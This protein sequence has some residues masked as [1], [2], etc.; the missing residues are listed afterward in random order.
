MS[1]TLLLTASTS[2]GSRMRRNRR[3]WQRRGESSA[4]D[5]GSSLSIISTAVRQW[6]ANY[7][8]RHLRCRA[9]I[10]SVR[11][12]NIYTRAGST[13]LATPPSSGAS[14]N[15]CEVFGEKARSG[16]EVAEIGFDFSS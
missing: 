13:K 16:E 10:W 6:R 2:R 14:S 7:W 15:R 3:D 11:L 12:S 8:Q 5:L 4:E 1:R 9:K